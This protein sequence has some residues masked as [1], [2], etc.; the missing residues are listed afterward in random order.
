MNTNQTRRDFLKKFSQLTLG[1]SGFYAATAQF[2]LANALVQPGDPYKALVCI[3]LLG[4]NDAFNTLVPLG[5]AEYNLYKTTRQTLAVDQAGLLPISPDNDLGLQLGLH[6]SMTGIQELF[7]NGQL[8]FISN[9]GALVEPVT[10]T[11]YKNNSVL[12]PPQLFSHNDQQSF[13]QSLQSGF[14]RNGWS[15][16]AADAM[17]GVNTNQKLSMNIS[18]G[19]SNLWQTG[20]NVV[21]Y[22][23]DASG[24]KELENFNKNST[25]QR[26]L[27][28]IQIYQTLL[29]Q[30]QSH[31]FVRE[32]ARSQ[33]LAWELSGEV[34]QAL[35]A[36]APL[37]TVFPANALAANLKMIAQ[38][39]SARAALGVTRQT[40]FVGMGDF[41][42]HGNQLNR[43]V[44][45]LAQLSSALK[46][47]YA[48]TV[49]LGVSNQVTCFTASDFGR[50]LTSNGDGTDHG[51]GSH[52]MIMG[53]AVKGKNIYG[54]Y[55]N[56][57]INSNDDIGEGR[58]IPTSSID[59]YAATLASWYGVPATEFSTVFPNL[60][61]FNTPTLDFFKS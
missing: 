14:K 40:F 22:S 41:D 23:V 1:A 32:F 13:V 6:P 12:L 34:K 7:A 27:S 37:T 19:G 47:F 51:W 9:V 45:L 60:H 57:T 25:D 55:P 17:L 43:H 38:L 26:E 36:Q 11:S 52:Q 46:S 29:S 35:D 48:A 10:K 21:P 39:I 53:G 56:L 44:S 16:R 20:A 58:I 33:A 54:T 50:T 49:E 24:V 5:D 3:F 31:P 18:L 42:T 59:Q 15:G 30:Q 61:R 4:G 28:R 8:A 2:Q